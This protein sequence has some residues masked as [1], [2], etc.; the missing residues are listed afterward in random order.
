[1]SKTASSPSNDF[2]EF[3]HL[4]V[5]PRHWKNES[6]KSA[7]D[8]TIV[9]ERDTGHSKVYRTH[10]RI[11]SSPADLFFRI[12]ASKESQD[13]CALSTGEMSNP[14]CEGDLELKLQDGRS[15]SLGFL[16][17]SVRSLK[18]QIQALLGIL[19]ADQ[20]LF[21]CHG[22]VQGDE[23]VDDW[24]SLTACGLSKG[25]TLLL[26]RRQWLQYDPSSRTLK[27]NLPEACSRCRQSLFC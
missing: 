2:L 16:S 8:F 17:N 5:K 1:M 21:S 20:R 22:G 7:S 10:L 6:D 23:L 15:F 3:E 9:L 26:V 14:T 25:D 19:V 27:L 12:A 24:R 18:E 4:R 13:L 11:L